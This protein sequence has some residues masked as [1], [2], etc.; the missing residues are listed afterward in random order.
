[1]M[2]EERFTLE[3]L[4][5][6][7]REFLEEYD[8]LDAQ[9]DGRVSEVP[10]ARTV[11]YYTTIGLLDRPLMEGRQAWYQRRHVLQILSIKALQSHHLP[12]AEI[13]S[14]LYGKTDQ[15]LDS[16]LRSLLKEKKSDLPAPIVWREVVIQPGLKIQVLE[17]FSSPLSAAQLQDR[18]LKAINVLTSSDGN[19]LEKKR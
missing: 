14:V 13:Q 7:M 5:A 11:R 17:N 6:K 10:D 15:E 19:K 12:L 18:I 1:M 16:L 8:L 9:H 4:S 2:K 3:S